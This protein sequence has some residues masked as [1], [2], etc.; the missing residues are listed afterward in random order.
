MRR[1]L[2]IDEAT[3]EVR[4]IMT[5]FYA[6]E[7]TRVEFRVTGSDGVALRGLEQWS[8]LEGRAVVHDRGL[9]RYYLP[10]RSVEQ[11]VYL[12]IQDRAVGAFKRMPCGL[13]GKGRRKSRCLLCEADSQVARR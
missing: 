7:H 2:H 6:G 8:H 5:D 1:F 13:A 10:R 12:A 4:L 3:G 9:D 11:E